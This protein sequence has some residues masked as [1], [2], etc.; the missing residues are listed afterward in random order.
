MG[1]AK[2]SA[3]SVPKGQTEAEGIRD[4]KR[5]IVGAKVKAIHASDHED[6][7]DLEREAWKL[8]LGGLDAI[9]FEIDGLGLSDEFAVALKKAGL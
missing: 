9:R 7:Y 1:R 2:P 3:E 8:G 5:Q 6:R 4:I